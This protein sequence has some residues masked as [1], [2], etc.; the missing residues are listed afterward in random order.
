MVNF[1]IV[2]ALLIGT[3]LFMVIRSKSSQSLRWV[4]YSLIIMTVF[5][6]AIAILIHL[7]EASHYQ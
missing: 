5:L 1:G 4:G 6:V 3:G 7:N 2:I